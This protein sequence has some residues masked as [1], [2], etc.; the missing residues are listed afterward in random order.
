MARMTEHKDASVRRASR[1]L[2]A[3]LACLSLLPNPAAGDP[4]QVELL[5]FARP[6]DPTALPEAPGYRPHCL[7]RAQPVVAQAS[8]AATLVGADQHR[9]VPEAQAIQRRGSGMHLLVHIAWQQDLPA[10]S[11]GPWI[12]VDDGRALSGCLRAWLAPVPEVELEVAYET[13]AGERFGLYTTAQVRP[14]DV[15]YFD[16]PALGALV[17]LDPLQE[18]AQPAPDEPAAGP[19]TREP[20]S[21]PTPGA[22]P[23]D[24]LPPPPKKP[25]RW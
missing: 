25:F 5:V 18:T 2:L 20:G 9:L 14:A 15:R 22:A 13:P 11:P 6:A 17:R 23:L 19:E 16:H 1:R 7:D 10:G 3:A 4:Y 24:A 12:R 21:A 8:G